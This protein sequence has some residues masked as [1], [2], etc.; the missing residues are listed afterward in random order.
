MGVAESKDIAFLIDFGITKQYRHPSSRIHI[1]MKEYRHLVGTPAFT[2]INSHLGNELSR[3]DDLEALAYTLMFLFSG[4]L[5]WLTQNCRGLSIRLSKEALGTK[6]PPDVPRELFS[7]LT[8]TRSL[9]FKQKPDY[10]F[11]RGILLS[12]TSSLVIVKKE[13]QVIRVVE[14]GNSSSNEVC[15]TDTPQT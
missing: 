8:Y 13:A 14:N 12:A 4:T 7:F 15:D 3:R 5:P 2:S 10:D 6:C 11:L 9:S 1:P